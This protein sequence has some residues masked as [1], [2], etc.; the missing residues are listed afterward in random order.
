MVRRFWVTVAVVL[1]SSLP[2]QAQDRPEP[3]STLEVQGGAAQNVAT[4]FLHE[5]W[6]RGRGLTA[7]VATPFYRGEAELG[8]AVHRYYNRQGV[9]VPGFDAAL[10]YAGWRLR[11]DLEPVTLAAGVRVGNY[12]MTFN[13]Q[14]FAGVR[15]ES[16]LAVMGYGRLA[17]RVVG[18]LSIYADAGHLRVYTF[19]RLKLWY[20]SV[21]LS[22]RF[23]TPDWLQ[24]GLR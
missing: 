8:A 18:P 15:N 23:G 11:A 12:R 21:G 5:Y 20:A 4:T 9:A 17:V 14:T 7:N 19:L 13:E 1:V 16:E 10:L 24:R 2:T 22:Y 6:E 3:F